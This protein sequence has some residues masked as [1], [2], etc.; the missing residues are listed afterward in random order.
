MAVTWEEILELTEKQHHFLRGLF[1]DHTRQQQSPAAMWTSTWTSGTSL[2]YVSGS[3]FDDVTTRSPVTARG[4][5][6]AQD[7]L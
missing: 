5:E 6:G 1:R 3:R 2:G 4:P 7:G